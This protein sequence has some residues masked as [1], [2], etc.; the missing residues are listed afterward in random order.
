MTITDWLY[1][2]FNSSFLEKEILGYRGPEMKINLELD[3]LEEGIGHKFLLPVTVQEYL[4]EET[5]PLHNVL[6]MRIKSSKTSIY[7]TSTANF[8]DV[9]SPR[10][11]I[12]ANLPTVEKIVD[13]VKV[14]LTTAYGDPALRFANSLAEFMS[15]Y[16]QQEP[17]LPLVRAPNG[18]VIHG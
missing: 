17:K 14:D 6:A 9:Q 13:W 5:E 12:T 1:S 11:A 7:D 2:K 8:F 18:C 3:H 16:C 15:Q 4:T 10:Y